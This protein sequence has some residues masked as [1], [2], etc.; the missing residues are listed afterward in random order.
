MNNKSITS[1]LIFG[2]FVNLIIHYSADVK[3][4]NKRNFIPLPGSLSLS[5]ANDPVTFRVLQLNVL[6]D[7][8]SG[9]RP[10][11][12]WYISSIMYLPYLIFTWCILSVGQFSR[13]TSPDVL[14]WNVR[15]LKLLHEITQYKPDVVTMF[16]IINSF[17]I[18][19]I[20]SINYSSSDTFCV[21]FSYIYV[22]M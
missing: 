14:N 2:I 22:Y 13:V 6:A 19:H 5:E 8:L 20:Y 21:L 3:V 11:Q 10:D 7:G 9:R 4:P 18:N 1:I 16:V 15:K 12:G 17:L